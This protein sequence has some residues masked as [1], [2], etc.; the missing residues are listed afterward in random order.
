MSSIA[1]ESFLACLA[2]MEVPA[3]VRNPLYFQSISKFC[4]TL[5]VNLASMYIFGPLMDWNL[6]VQSQ[7]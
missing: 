3:K 6:V 2:L 4:N 7:Q 1:S 5:N